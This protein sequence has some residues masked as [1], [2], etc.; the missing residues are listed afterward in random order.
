MGRG[1]GSQDWGSSPG[2]ATYYVFSENFFYLFELE[3]I[4]LKL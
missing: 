1:L 3:F 4:V 2:C